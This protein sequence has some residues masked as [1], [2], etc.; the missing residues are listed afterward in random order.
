MNGL[1]LRI[2][3]GMDEMIKTKKVEFEKY[4]FIKLD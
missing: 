3:T 2:K 4:F 1:N